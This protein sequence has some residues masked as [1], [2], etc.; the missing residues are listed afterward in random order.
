MRLVKLLIGD[1]QQGD[2]GRQHMKQKLIE[3]YSQNNFTLRVSSLNI[4]WIHLLVVNIGLY[5]LFVHY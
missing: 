2:D 4:I 3:T 5:V 1:D